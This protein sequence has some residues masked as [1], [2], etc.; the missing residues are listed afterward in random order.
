MPFLLILRRQTATKTLLVQ[1]STKMFFGSFVDCRL[2][3]A[4]AKCR[5][6]ACRN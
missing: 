1:S 6:F 3:R 4:N 2:A 5:K